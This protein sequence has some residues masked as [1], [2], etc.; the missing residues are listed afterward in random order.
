MKAYKPSL[1]ELSFL[2]EAVQ[3]KDFCITDEF[4]A[5]ARELV[6]EYGHAPEVHTAL[7]NVLDELWERRPQTARAVTVSAIGD[8]DKAGYKAFE[9]KLVCLW[10]HMFTQD[11]RTPAEL[12]LQEIKEIGRYQNGT[13]LNV[14]AQSVRAEMKLR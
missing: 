5:A 11:E 6:T 14:R 4:S 9:Q 7:I 1:P 8:A 10:G 13:A 2:E 3:K 12:K